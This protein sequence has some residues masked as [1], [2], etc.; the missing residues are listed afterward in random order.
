MIIRQ[1]TINDYEEVLSL[2]ERTPGIGISE[3]DTRDNMY[4]FLQRNPC[5]NMVCQMD[6]RIVGTILCGSDGRRGYIYH[7]AVEREYR[8]RGIALELVKEV[9]KRLRVLGIDKCHLFVF[10][11]NKVGQDFWKAVGWQRR[12]DL[13]IFSKRSGES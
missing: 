8:L 12:D 1:M 9:L 4:R 10:A 2:W 7:T 3:A 5:L 13:L 6:N 11:D